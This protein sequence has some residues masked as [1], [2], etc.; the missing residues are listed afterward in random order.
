ME[1]A[2][3]IETINAQLIDLYGI[4]TVTGKSM[5][6]VVWSEDQL[7]K[8]LVDTLDSGLILSKP[9]V[10]EVP[11]YRPYINEKYVLER[12]VVVPEINQK[13]LPVSKLSYE[14]MWT[15]MDA[16][17]NYLPPRIDA[18]QFIVDTLYAAMGKQSLAKYKDPDAGLSTDDQ[19]E[20][21]LAQIQELELSMFG[22]ETE[23]TDALAHG[24]GIVVPNSYIPQKES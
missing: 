16:Q 7:E 15:F 20:K 8:R 23:V 4:D 2:E 10:R 21:K 12:L 5:W 14:P 6:R 13:N 22:N 17:G 11:K 19:K 24:E 9:V 1:L 18:C 3:T